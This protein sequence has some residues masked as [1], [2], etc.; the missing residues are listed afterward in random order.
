VLEKIDK[1]FVRKT[2]VNEVSQLPVVETEFPRA[3]AKQV[4]GIFALMSIEKGNDSR[5]QVIDDQ[6]KFSVI[7]AL[8]W[9]EAFTRECVGDFP[10]LDG[11]PA[12]LR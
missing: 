5:V 7:A 3:Q 6:V 2:A 12:N 11:R 10:S 8:Y 4:V 9:S 1:S